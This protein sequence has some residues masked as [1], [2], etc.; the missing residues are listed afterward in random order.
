MKYVTKIANSFY[1]LDEYTLPSGEQALD[2]LFRTTSKTQADKFLYRLQK[3][4]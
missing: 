4:S 1:V 3:Q 2:V